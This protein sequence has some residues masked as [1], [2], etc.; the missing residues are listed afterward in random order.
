MMQTARVNPPSPTM[1]QT[2][3]PYRQPVLCPSLT[4]TIDE[5]CEEAVIERLESG[6]TTGDDFMEHLHN[7]KLV[8]AYNGGLSQHTKK[9][10]SA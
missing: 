4:H 5:N 9:R 8:T 2:A 3:S 7:V 1:M 10:R 6:Q